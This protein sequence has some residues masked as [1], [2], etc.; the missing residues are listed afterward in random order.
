[1]ND[2]NGKEHLRDIDVRRNVGI[3]RNPLDEI[4]AGARLARCAEQS[5][6][7][8]RTIGGQ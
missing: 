7:G 4:K 2:S 6:S 1:M 3:D 8:S 5:P